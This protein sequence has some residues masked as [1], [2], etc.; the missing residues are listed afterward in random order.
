[1]SPVSQDLNRGSWLVHRARSV[2]MAGK[3]YRS[4]ELHEAR[5]DL[6][7]ECMMTLVN[8][9]S[10]RALYSLTGTLTQSSGRA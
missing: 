6:I 5:R 9:V 4:S 8:Q 3:I 7:S 1:M 2:T 10:G